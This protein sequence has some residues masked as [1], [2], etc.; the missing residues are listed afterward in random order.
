MCPWGGRSRDRVV[1]AGYLVEAAADHEQRI[2]RQE[3]LADHSGGAISGGTHEVRMVVGE[4][5]G[6]TPGGKDG[7]VERLAELDQRVPCPGRDDT[8]AGQDGWTPC[9]V[10]QFDHALN[11]TV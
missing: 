7:N 6:P 3:S 5:R 4:C 1:E 10:E 9:C 2:S 11:V 8:V